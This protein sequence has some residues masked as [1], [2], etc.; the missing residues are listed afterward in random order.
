MSEYMPNGWSIIH[1]PNQNEYFVFG[2]WSGSYTE[3]PSW[4]VNSGIKNIAEQTEG[5]YDKFGHVYHVFGYS[6]SVYHLTENGEDRH[7][8]YALGILNSILEQHEK[9]GARCVTMKEVI[10]KFEGAMV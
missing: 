7:S 10:E 6:G 8:A 2:S 4:R 5:C 1:L 3:G 9:D